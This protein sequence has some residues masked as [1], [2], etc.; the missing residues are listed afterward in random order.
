MHID[1][2]DKGKP[3]ERRGRKTTGLRAKA[4]DSGATEVKAERENTTKNIG[5]SRPVT[6]RSQ[7]RGSNTSGP[8]QSALGR[9]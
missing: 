6:R 5:L 4:Y 3:P 7:L 1:A 8:T 2:S 9:T